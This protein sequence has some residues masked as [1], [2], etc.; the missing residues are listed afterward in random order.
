[1]RGEVLN[2]LTGVCDDDDDL[3]RVVLIVVEDPNLHGA[4]VG[5]KLDRVR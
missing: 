1:M 2:Q 4:V 3:V 5:R